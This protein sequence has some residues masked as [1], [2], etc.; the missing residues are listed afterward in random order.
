VNEYE[1]LRASAGEKVAETSQLHEKGQHGLEE[2]N[3]ETGDTG[4]WGHFRLQKEKRERPNQL[5][6]SRAKTGVEGETRRTGKSCLRGKR[7]VEAEGVQ[8]TT[9]RG[10]NKWSELAEYRNP[11]VRRHQ[12]ARGIT[13]E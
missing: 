11:K 12:K 6:I 10:A 3:T 5:A 1:P 8:T 7:K 2:K 13:N 9:Y 4:E